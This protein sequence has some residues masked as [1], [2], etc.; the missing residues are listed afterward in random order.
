MTAVVVTYNRRDLLLESLAAVTAQTRAPD[1]V[2]R[3]GQRLDR[4]HRRRGARA[5]PGRAA[6]HGAAATPAARAGSP[7][8]WRWPWPRRRSGLADGRRH[9]A[10][11]GRAGGAARRPGAAPGAAPG[12]DR[13]PG[14]V[15]RRPAAPDEHPADQAVR[16]AGRAPGGGRRGCVP[17]RSAS[18]VSILVDAAVCRDRGLPQADYFLWNDDFEF[19]TRLLRGQAGL[20]CP[21]SVV[22]HKTGRSAPPTPTPASGSSTRCGTRS[23]RCGPAPRWPPRSACCTAGRRCAAG[24]ARSRGPATGARSGPAWLAGAGGR[25]AD[26]PAAHRGGAGVSRA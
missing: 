1:T 12:A 5:L 2:H 25:G 15:D 9:R 13:Q 8:A 10:R 22:V 26:Q 20:L 17:I 16:D 18:F 21:A 4:R 14:G 11:A 3:G 23:G 7:T 6:G 19:T 24:P